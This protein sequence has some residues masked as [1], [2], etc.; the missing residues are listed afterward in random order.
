VRDERLLAEIVK[1]KVLCANCHAV[2]QWNRRN[3]IAIMAPRK[4][5]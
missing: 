3:T 2:E 1:R 4:H 5:L